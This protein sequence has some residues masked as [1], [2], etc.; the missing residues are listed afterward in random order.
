MADTDLEF[1][2]DFKAVMTDREV[3]KIG[4]VVCGLGYDLTI[5]T[6]THFN[7]YFYR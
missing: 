1:I 3:K 5:K 7:H 6:I 2:Q 4:F